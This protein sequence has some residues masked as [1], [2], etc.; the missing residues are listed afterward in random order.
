MLVLKVHGRFSVGAFLGWNIQ[1]ETDLPLPVSSHPSEI[2]FYACKDATQGTKTGNVKEIRGTNAIRSGP[3]NP[4][5]ESRITGIAR[6]A[7][8]FGGPTRPRTSQK[9]QRW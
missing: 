3:P 1:P 5:R 6:H 7:R 9:A 8:R 2:V 4:P